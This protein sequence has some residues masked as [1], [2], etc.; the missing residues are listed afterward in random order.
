MWWIKPKCMLGRTKLGLDLIKLTL[1]GSEK[2]LYTSPF[3]WARTQIVHCLQKHS[4]GQETRLGLLPI[5]NT[6]EWFNS[7]RHYMERNTKVHVTNPCL[8]WNQWEVKTLIA[9]SVITIIKQIQTVEN[10]L[11]VQF[12]YVSK[13]NRLCPLTIPPIY[14][15]ITTFQPFHI[16][17]EI[18]P[19][20]SFIHRENSQLLEKKNGSYKANR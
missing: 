3:N 10:R 19:L 13:I 20:W 6:N 8:K 17:N 11:I 7:N 4:Q 15:I 5:S 9:T 16:K 14:T 2:K 12:L 18:S 1:D